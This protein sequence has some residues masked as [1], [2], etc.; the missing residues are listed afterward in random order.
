MVFFETV[1]EIMLVAV[2]AGGGDFRD[3]DAAGLLKNLQGVFHP[4]PDQQVYLFMFIPVKMKWLALLDIVFFI[5]GIVREGFP[6]S[7]IPIVALLNFLIFCGGDILSLIPGISRRPK[8]INYK[9]A[10]R[11]V[12]RQQNNL[13][14]SA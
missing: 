4:F 2:T 11:R 6:N 9:E 12:N 7:L 10:A 3:A 14:Q 1:A 13:V 5:T 8:V